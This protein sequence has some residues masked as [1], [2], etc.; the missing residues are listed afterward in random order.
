[1][2][3]VNVCTLGAAGALGA[4]I[5]ALPVAE[6]FVP[7]GD[8]IFPARAAWDITKPPYSAVG[9]GK[10]GGRRVIDGSVLISAISTIRPLCRTAVTPT[11]P[12]S[13]SASNTWLICSMTPGW[14]S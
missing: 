1:M 3:F 12:A 5:S 2:V 8:I 13:A 6:G 7:A 11:A 14:F 4:V 9:D 10:S